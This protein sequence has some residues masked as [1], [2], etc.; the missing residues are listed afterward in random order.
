MIKTLDIITIKILI[1]KIPELFDMFK[2]I[3]DTLDDGN[4][5]FIN[6]C[7]ATGRL[8]LSLEAM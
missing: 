4:R 3:T 5:V 8:A 6:G 2:A 7:G 1:N